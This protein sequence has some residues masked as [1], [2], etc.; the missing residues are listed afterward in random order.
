[1]YR[2]LLVACAVG[3]SLATC[4]AAWSATYYVSIKSGNDGGSGLSPSNA[5]KTISKVNRSRFYPGDQI[6]FKCGEK[7]RE[8]LTVSSSG[9]SAAPITYGSYGTDSK[10]EINGSVAVNSWLKENV[11]GKR[12]YSA[13]QDT[14]G[15]ALSRPDQVFRNDNRLASTTKA[16]ADMGI[17]QWKWVNQKLYVNIGGDLSGSMVEASSRARYAC[18]VISAKHFITLKN[19]ALQKANQDGLFITNGSSNIHL[20]NITTSNNYWAGINVWDAS[21]KQPSGS[22]ENSLIEGNGGNGIHLSDA[23]QW[24]I[25]GND[26]HSNCKLKENRNHQYTAGI[27]LNGLTSIDNIVE[28]NNVSGSAWGS[29]IWL[30]FCGRNNIV[31]Y[32]NVFDN[33]SAGIMNEITSGTRIYYNKSNFNGRSYNY[34]GS[35]CTAAGIFIWGRT[36]QLPQNG[37]ANDN[38]VYN[39]LCYANLYIGIIIQ[40]DGKSTGI[41]DRNIV[42]NNVSV[43]NPTQFRAGGGAER[44]AAKTN[45]KYN[46]FGNEIRRFIEWGWGIYKSTYKDWE[47]VYGSET[48]SIKASPLFVDAAKED[49]KLQSKSPCINAG[50]PVGL[51]HDLSGNSISDNPDVGPYEWSDTRYSPPKQLKIK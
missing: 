30:D 31:R 51:T 35:Q 49:F 17:N 50:T 2:R 38:I 20:S 18:I 5:W 23:Q 29:G 14:D 27:K 39:N 43:E 44:I 15:Q 42:M 13:R 7:W 24:K 12:I 36:G 45:I 25:S 48:Y 47:A 9:S 26:V 46:C 19:I 37:P 22:V 32:N 1:M 33:Y 40:G 10:P 34:N 41:I 4:Q 28:H 11:P 8:R 6:L 3:F 16:I 21:K